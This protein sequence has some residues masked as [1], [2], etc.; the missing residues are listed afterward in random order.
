MPDLLLELLSE[1]IPA[2]MQRRAAEDLKSLI[3]N[4]LVDRG[5]TY[6]GAKAF[7]TPRRLAL[8]IVGLPIKGRDVREEKKGPRLGAPDAAIQGFLRSAGLSDIS[9]ATIEKD[10][11]KGEFYVAIIEKPGQATKDALADIIPQVIRTFPW[12]K[13]MRWGEASAPIGTPYSTPRAKGADALRWVRPLQSIVCTFGPETEDPDIIKFE[14][15]GIVSG[16]LTRGHRFLSPAAFR[17]KRFDDYIV[18]LERAHVVLDADRRKDIILTDAR[19]L[20]MAQNLD[21]IEDE[22]LLEE[23]AGL[24]EWPVVLMGTF[25]DSFLDAPAEVIRA[26]I[27]ANQKCFVLRDPAT[28]GLANKFILTS[29]MIGSDGGATIVAGNGRVIRARL[30]DALYFWKTDQGPLPDYVNELN[31]DKPLDQRL[32]KL[33]A[34]NVVFHEKL[35]TQGERVERIKALAMELARELG[36]QS[37]FTGKLLSSDDLSQ[38]QTNY[39]KRAGRPPNSARLT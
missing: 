35:R 10:P 29:N 36:R 22:G 19:T 34:L 15:D 14:V 17:V 8:T 25:D 7:A 4:A 21:L 13:S 11:K 26:T 30:S 20:A 9:Q 39:I 32:A 5:L 38:E 37:F 28:G 27:R 16:D 6:E 31:R 3:T 33:K 2:R 24:V 1:E 23:A 18:K 12:P